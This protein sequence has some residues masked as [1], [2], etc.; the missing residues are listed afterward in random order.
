MVRTAFLPLPQSLG[1][2]ALV[3]IAGWAGFFWTFFWGT[4]AWF[5]VK[6]ATSLLSRF[7]QRALTVL[8]DERR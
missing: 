6:G 2:D 7:R 8:P 3:V 5:L 4:A 1:M